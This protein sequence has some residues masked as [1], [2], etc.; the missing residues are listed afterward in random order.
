MPAE[1]SN[2]LVAH[3]SVDR[4]EAHDEPC[5]ASGRR[6]H[7]DQRMLAPHDHT[8]PA[9]S[10]IWAFYRKRYSVK[11]HFGANVEAVV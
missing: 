4:G 3:A 9:L 1:E 11:R 10:S 5:Q 2:H 8:S 7:A 6:Q